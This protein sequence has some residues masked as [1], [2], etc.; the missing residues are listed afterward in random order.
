MKRT[1]IVSA[2]VSAAVGVITGIVLKK[3]FLGI[4]EKVISAVKSDFEILA[5]GYDDLYEKISSCGCCDFDLRDL[6]EEDEK[7]E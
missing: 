7:H 1:V 5:G 2:A 6:V 4:C 3:H